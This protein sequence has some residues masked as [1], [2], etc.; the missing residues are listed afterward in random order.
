[1][2]LGSEAI[3]L[4]AVSK[5]GEMLLETAILINSVEFVDLL[6]RKKP[7]PKRKNQKGE[8][9][10]SIAVK[11]SINPEIL[12]KLMANHFDINEKLS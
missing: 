3:D 11:N 5:D 8:S 1:M 12:K 4:N 7:N 2:L 6:L 10:L 9:V